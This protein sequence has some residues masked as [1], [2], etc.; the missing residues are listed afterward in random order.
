MDD[1]NEISKKTQEGTKTDED[2]AVLSKDAEI[3][4]AYAAHQEKGTIIA[5]TY[6]SG[7]SIEIGDIS[8]CLFLKI[9]RRG[10][11]YEG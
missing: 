11:D 8:L 6:L 7:S 3:I 10:T 1:I 5:T 4:L 9:S 2:V